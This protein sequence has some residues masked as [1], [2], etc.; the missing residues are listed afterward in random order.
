MAEEIVGGSF[1]LNTDNL[2]AG[3]AEAKR[4]FQ[5][6]DSEAKKVQAS[7]DDWTKSQEGLEAELD[8]LRQKL[9]IQG[10]VV[11]AYQKRLKTLQT[12]EGAS[13]AELRNAQKQLNDAQTSYNKLQRAINKYEGQLD[14]LTKSQ[15]QAGNSTDKL[16]Q[17]QTRLGKAASTLNTVLKT[18][19]VLTIGHTLVR[20]ASDAVK[21]LVEYESAFT[22]VRKTVDGTEAEFEAMNSA[23]NAMARTMPQSAADIAQV[24]ALGGQLGIAAGD[25]E[26]FARTMIMLGDSTDLTAES[27][28]EMIAQ[29]GNITGLRAEDYE[30][31]GS[32]LV[33]LG[34][35]S[36]ATESAILEMANRIGRFGASVGLTN[37]DV[38]ALSS[39][40]ASMGVEAETGSSSMQRL[41]S[42]MQ[43]ASETGNEML[44]QFAAI[45]GMTRDEF[46]A[47][48]EDDALGA[49]TAFIKGLKDADSQGQ[50]TIGILDELGMTDVRLS[51]NIQALVAGYDTL[52][53]SIETADSAWEDNT[54]LAQEATT[55]YETLASQIG[56]MKNAWNEAG[57]DMAE[58]FAPAIEGAIGIL[59]DIGNAISDM[60]DPADKLNN[61][62]DVLKDSV[63]YLGDENADTAGKIDETTRALKEQMRQAAYSSLLETARAYENLSESISKTGDALVKNT[64]DRNR[65]EADIRKMM[66]NMGISFDDFRDNLSLFGNDIAET[67]A[68]LRQGV[69]LNNDDLQNLIASYNLWIDA[70]EGVTEAQRDINRDWTKQRAILGVIND[71]YNENSDYV[72]YMIG[73]YENLTDALNSYRRELEGVAQTQ[74]EILEESGTLDSII[75][76]TPE[77]IDLTHYDFGK[78]NIP[79]QDAT[80]PI[81]ILPDENTLIDLTGFDFGESNGPVQDVEVPVRIIPD[82]TNT[83]IIPWW[84]TGSK[85]AKE[86]ADGFNESFEGQGV[87]EQAAKSLQEAFSH[88]LDPI[89]DTFTGVMETIDMFTQ[90]ELDETEAKLDQLEKSHEE[91]MEKISEQSEER[92]KDLKIQYE[93]GEVTQAEYY[94]ALAASQAKQAE[95][96]KTLNEEKAAQE[97][98]LLRKKDELQ[99]RQFEAEKANAIAD[100][101]ISAAQAIMAAWA[102]NWILGAVM[103]GV[104]GGV[105][106]AQ[107][108]AVAQQ[109]YIPAL[110]EG[111]VVSSP[112]LALIGEEQ[113]G[114]PEMVAPLKQHTEWMDMIGDRVADVIERREAKSIVNNSSS[115]DNRQWTINQHIMQSEAPDRRIVYLQARKALREAR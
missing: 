75:R 38:L 61:N 32:T 42:D 45:S 107:T 34:N 103:T 92:E 52:T 68:Y 74:T 47:A 108:V 96:E 58:I 81:R 115:A 49:V 6:L 94:R 101:W 76:Y 99:R 69:A 11:E 24:F 64:S 41:F 113:G 1:V 83:R 3:V 2:V 40:L 71:L 33:A 20:A 30:R 86:W 13:A 14:N 9:Q 112:T 87:V 110:A 46:A 109:K 19:I 57:R 18:G 44:D 25:L 84:E 88:I 12:Q 10:Q 78:P 5:L 26:D 17:S 29:L 63:K 102:Q 36:A 95:D 31:F 85:A 111:G 54:A 4:Q 79:E 21:A 22:D 51:A 23:I 28:A 82:E 48:F 106:T 16:T 37:Q 72:T 90:N 39:A 89:V 55:R 62:L 15:N 98:E 66:D 104:I 7:F 65:Y 93:Q 56:M 8:K 43:L 73:D 53:A 35:S 70:S 67:V 97:E 60:I 80:V 50:S 59:T 114:S 91:A 27:A 105:A 77:F 100:I